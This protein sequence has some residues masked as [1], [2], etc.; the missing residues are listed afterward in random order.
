[1]RN[2]NQVGLVVKIPKRNK[3]AKK[4]LPKRVNND[5]RKRHFSEYKAG[6]V[7]EKNK[8]KRILKDA[9]RSSNPVK[10]AINQ[11]KKSSGTISFV[12]K[13]LLKKNLI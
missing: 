8:A 5:N 13:L 4:G 1:M 3:D 11:A 10:V 6:K 9:L 12:E 2:S 7:R